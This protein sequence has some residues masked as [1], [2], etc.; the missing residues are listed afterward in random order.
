LSDTERVALR[1][2]ATVGL[3]VTLI[4]QFAPAARLEPH[5]F[6][7]AKSPEFVPEMTMLVIVRD[8]APVF[9]SVTSCAV[10]VVLTGWL[11]ND[12]VEGLSE[13]IGTDVL[14]KVLTVT[15]APLTVTVRLVGV[16]VYPIFLGVTV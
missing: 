15:F 10:L 8:A 12:K 1:A 14:V 7:A 16:K 6:V 4:V 13:A 11:P 3:N 2:A 9:E 5:V